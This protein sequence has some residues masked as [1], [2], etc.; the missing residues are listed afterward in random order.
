[1]VCCHLIC[2]ILINTIYSHGAGHK[3]QT[4]SDLVKRIDYVDANGIP[5]VIDE[6]D[7]EFLSAASGCFGLLG[8]ITHL[9]LQLSP[10]S[11]AMLRPVKVDVIRAI[12]PPPGMKM[13]DIP[14]MLRKNITE[15]QRAE[16]QAD[17]ER[18]ALEDYYAEWFWFPYHDKVWINTWDKTDDEVGVHAY[19][20]TWGK[21]LQF[22]ETITIQILQSTSTY[23]L[24]GKWF[25]L[26]TT[27]IISRCAVARPP[28]LSD[29]LI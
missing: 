3:Q 22:V 14:P 8:V 28:T 7:K 16:D 9:T 5:R 11:Y 15:K 26:R 20:G 24:F 27:T 21:I 6:H 29:N 23:R 25:A 10:M 4:L 12:P 1:M 13:E 18:R 2:N 19:P 17:F